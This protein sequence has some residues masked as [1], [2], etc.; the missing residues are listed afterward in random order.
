[1]DFNV[2]LVFLHNAYILYKKKVEAR[3]HPWVI[4]DNV[5]MCESFDYLKSQTDICMRWTR[6]Y[7]E[8]TNIRINLVSIILVHTHQASNADL[9][10]QLFHLA[11]QRESRT[12][13]QIATST[14]KVSRV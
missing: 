6:T 10:L 13:T 5:N 4:G 2:Q 12:N 11:N 8:R 14:A 3:T 7:H 9:V 1:M